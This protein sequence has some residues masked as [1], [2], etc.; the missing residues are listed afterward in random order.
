[1]ETR[2]KMLTKINPKAARQ[3]IE[4]AQKDVHARWSLYEQMA[5]LDY[6]NN[7]E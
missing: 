6:S 2:Y 1:M 7:G 3:L 4:T 5:Q